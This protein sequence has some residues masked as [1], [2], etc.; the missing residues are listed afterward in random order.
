MVE[1]QRVKETAPIC[2]GAREWTEGEG[3]GKA[4]PAFT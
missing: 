4:G 3:E 2:Q 1:A